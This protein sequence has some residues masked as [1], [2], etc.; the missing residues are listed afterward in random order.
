MASTKFKD[1]EQGG[2]ITKTRGRP[3]GKSIKLSSKAKETI[4]E[5]TTDSRTLENEQRGTL[6]EKPTKKREKKIK[7]G[8]LSNGSSSASISL[9]DEEKLDQLKTIMEKQKDITEIDEAKV[10]RLKEGVNEALRDLEIPGTTIIRSREEARRVVQ[11]L[12]AYPD[13]IHAWDTETI[14]I[15]AKEESPVG[16]GQIICAT[17]F[18][19]PDVD[20]GNGPRLFIDNYADALNTIMEFKEYLEDPNYLKCWHNYG[21]DRHIFFNH[22]IN[23]QGFGADTMHMARLYDPSKMPNQYS[24]SALSE[25]LKGKITEQ[26]QLMIQDL[27]QKLL[28]D[29]QKNETQ[30]STLKDGTKGKVL[31]FPDVEV[32]H[33]NKVEEWVGYSCYDAEIT[34]FLRETLSKLLMTQQTDEE[35]MQ[36]MLGLY[37]KY[38]RAFGEVLTDMER[39]GIKIDVEYLKEIQ[40][41]AEKDKSQYEEKFLEWVY[42]IQED[43]KEFNPA[44]AHQIQQLL[45]APF[46]KR[47]KKPT[48]D[49]DGEIMYEYP[50]ERLFKVENTAGFIKEGK[51][52]ALKQREM[53]ITGLGIPALDYTQSSLPSADTPVI[54]RLAGRPDKGEFG[55]A[56]NFFLRQDKEEEGKECCW[57]LWNWIQYKGIETL[58]NTY[59]LPLQKAPDQHGRIHCSMNLNTETGRLSCRKPNL[60][61]QPA[62]DKDKYKIRRAFVADQGNKLVVADYGQLELRVLAHMANCKG[63][64]DAFKL[65]GDFHSRTALG[66]YPEIKKDLESGEILLE[67][68][69]SK[70]KAPKPLLKDKYANERKK[71]KIMNFSIAY[72]KTVH[73]FMKDWNC[74]KEE[75]QATVELWYSDRPEVKEWQK[76]IQSKAITRG[77]TQTLLGRYRNLTKHFIMSSTNE[78]YSF[79]SNMMKEHGLRAAINTPIQGGAADIVIAAMV[80]LHKDQMLKDLGYKLLLQIHDEVI[81]EGPEKYAKEALERVIYIM[82]NPLD[83]RLRVKLEVDAKIATTWY[84]GK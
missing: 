36:D 68:D 31:T 16:H 44:S 10:I 15:D 62:L 12:K 79:K 1:I 65:G 33:T 41:I 50:K 40:L 14:H 3:K 72:G 75:A 5:Y 19:G 52:Q 53:K 24:L 39:E 20:F 83:N 60:Q 34:F 26:K 28:V 43:A 66:M 9:T 2:T 7:D 84:E 69:N 57:A 81:L 58:L 6:K 55:E 49:N 38:W 18:I 56:Y 35:G 27:R 29:P 67:W 11:I 63:M 47:G 77:W 71:A 51:K 74:S 46:N 8:S 59:I 17:V 37:S 73:G 25:I 61:N 4:K 80:K 70:G 54:K 21:Y 30:L 64:I 32:I 78:G 45:F 13:R 48:F 82:E 23:V 22:G 76:M 42:K